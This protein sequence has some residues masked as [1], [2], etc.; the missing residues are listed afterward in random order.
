[1]NRRDAIRMGLLLT[2]YSVL[3][4]PQ[5]AA[6]APAGGF[7]TLFDGKN[8]DNFDQIGN[9]N[10]RI[11]DGAVQANIGNG[12]LVSKQS[13]KDFILRVEVWVDEPANS[14]VFIRAQNPLNM[15]GG[16]SYECNIFDTR[17]DPSYGTGAIVGVAK[18][19]PMPKAANKWNV[20]EIE[21]RGPNMQITFNGKVTSK[22][23]DGKNPQGRFGLQYGGGIVRF[24]KVEIRTL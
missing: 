11:V 19:D 2:G 8:L 9:A 12:F 4:R 13:Y 5:L 1:M 10:W 20:M 15:G 16:T 6:A 7:V 14:G 23:S 21:A 24:R 17:P 3:A 22:G 18:V